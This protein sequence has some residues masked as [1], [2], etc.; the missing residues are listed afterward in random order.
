MELRVLKA[1]DEAVEEQQLRLLDLV[2]QT[3]EESDRVGVDLY[4]LRAEASAVDKENL[5]SIKEIAL[6][7]SICTDQR[8]LN[9]KQFCAMKHCKE[10]E[11]EHVADQGEFAEKIHRLTFERDQNE[12]RMEKAHGLLDHTDHT[13]SASFMNVSQ[14][15]EEIAKATFDLSQID[16]ELMTLETQNEF[17]V[18]EQEKLSEHL[19]FMA[20]AEMDERLNMD[21]IVV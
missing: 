1:E 19:D 2:E 8:E 10:V 9:L 15:N 16:K 11:L 6:R 5:D 3:N 7:E 17:H 4:R 21:Q 12:K 20:R 14:A 18:E 13:I